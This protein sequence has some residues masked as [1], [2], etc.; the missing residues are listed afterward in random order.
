MRAAIDVGIDA[1]YR[2][3][4]LATRLGKRGEHP[5]LLLEL[6]VELPYAGVECIGELPIG[7]ADAGEDDVRC[8]DTGSERAAHLSTQDDVGTE[9]A[10]S[11]QMQHRAVRV[12]LDRERRPRP[13]QDRQRRCETPG[14]VA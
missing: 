3:R 2:D 11:Q 9:A 13:R 12:C 14:R 4:P 1:Q 10:A 7:L 6:E 5:P 8:G